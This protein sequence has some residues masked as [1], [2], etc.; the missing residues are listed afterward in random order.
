MPSIDDC[1]PQRLHV[2]STTPRVTAGQLGRSD[3]EV[4]E[5]DNRTAKRIKCNMLFW[6][7]SEDPN[8]A[9]FARTDF[10]EWLDASGKGTGVTYKIDTHRKRPHG[11]SF[12]FARLMLA[13]KLAL[14]GR[15][16]VTKPNTA[17][18]KAKVEHAQGC[19]REDRS[20]VVTQLEEFKSPPPTAPAGRMGRRG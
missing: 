16:V 6:G 20:N 18:Q 3:D 11:Q 7:G 1:P 17:V 2:S 12:Q 13:R 4:L 10:R 5:R 8:Q 14:A 15:A 19:K 9:S